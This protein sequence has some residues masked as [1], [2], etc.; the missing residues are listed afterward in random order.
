M[1][2]CNTL[3]GARATRGPRDQGREDGNQGADASSSTHR[4]VR[5][6]LQELMKRLS[7]EAP[8]PPSPKRPTQ[9]RGAG[10][11]RRTASPDSSAA[12][13]SAARIHRALGDEERIRL[14]A[15]LSTGP[16]S[17]GE[18]AAR[19]R[20][21]LP[22]VSQRLKTLL[23][24]GLVGRRRQGQNVLYSLADDHVV[25]LVRNTLVHA[26]EDRRRR[27]APKEGTEK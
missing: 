20:S 11:S 1:A 17:V 8:Q 14:C 4:A 13:A 16:C 19:T 9:V 5:D 25:E 6:T 18:L 22:T 23:T 7:P 10:R 21:A 26:E 24:A 27:R 12:L 15:L 3:A 2:P